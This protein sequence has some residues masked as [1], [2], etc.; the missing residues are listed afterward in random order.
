M[1]FIQNTNNGVVYMTAPNISAKHCFTT[2]LGGVS[3]GHLS[4]L[5]LGEN[6]GDAPENVI[7]NYRRLGEATGIATQIGRAQRLNSSHR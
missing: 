6:R 1:P 4:S 5:N 7:E 2:R 3:S